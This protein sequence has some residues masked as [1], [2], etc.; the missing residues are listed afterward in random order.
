LMD[1]L[2][3]REMLQ[4]F[5]GIKGIPEDQ[6]DAVVESLIARMGLTQHADNATKGYSGGN[7][8]KLSMA[9]A[10]IG[11]PKLVFLD[12]PSS[13][14]DPFA[15]REMWKVISSSLAGCSVILTTHFM[16]EADAL[17]QRIG[18]M[19]NGRLCCL[20]SSQH[21]KSTY[22][23]GYQIEIS[24]S[25]TDEE[26]VSKLR[27][28]LQN[29]A[30]AQ[31]ATTSSSSSVVPRDSGVEG[32]VQ[33]LEWHGGHIRCELPSECISLASVFQKV[34]DSKHD[35]KITDYAVSQ[36]SLEKVFLS[37]AKRQHEEGCEYLSDGQSPAVTQRAS[38]GGSGLK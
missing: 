28:F 32:E 26:S 12:E 1:H 36:T 29:L 37:F 14:M 5:A 38:L 17:C 3:G 11:S 31:S 18:I 30:P 21:L 35:L 9:L 25:A 24:T 22:G 16:E 6:V 33:F 27:T 8:R 23:T 10:L 34:E 13:G 4:V 15:R 2:T 20:G 19:V 7:K